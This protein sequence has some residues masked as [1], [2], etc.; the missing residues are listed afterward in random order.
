M[1]LCGKGLKQIF[2]RRYTDVTN[3]LQD[4]I[5]CCKTTQPKIMLFE[6]RVFL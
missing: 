3:M 2:H 4:K 6:L 1:C 5:P